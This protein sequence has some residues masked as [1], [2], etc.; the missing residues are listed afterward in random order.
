MRYVTFA[1]PE[2][3]AAWV[4]ANACD[5]AAALCQYYKLHSPEA[6]ARSVAR[7]LR[8]TRRNLEIAE[9]AG[10]LKDGMPNLEPMPLAPG[11]CGV[12]SYE[13][14]MMQL[15][16]DM[17]TASEQELREHFINYAIVARGLDTTRARSEYNRTRLTLVKKGYLPKIT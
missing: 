14:H 13:Q 6:T 2:W 9:T 15:R 4:S 1:V 8:V 11:R 3:L 10:A 7:G 17:P 16:K 12:P 5:A